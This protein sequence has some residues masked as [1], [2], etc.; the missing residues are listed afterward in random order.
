MSHLAVPRR[1]W[2][3]EHLATFLL[4]RIAFMAHPLT[5]ADDIGSDFFCTLFKA[6]EQ[7]GTEKLFPTNS[8]AIQIKSN[9]DKFSATNKVEYLSALE[10][11]FFVGAVDRAKLQLSIYSGEYIP[12][13]F[14]RTYPTTLTLVPVSALGSSQYC[15][16]ASD[17]QTILRLPLVCEI[18]AHERLED[19]REKGRLLNKL[20]SL[21]HSNISARANSEYIFQLN[22][23]EG[24][25]WMV[26]AGRD[27]VTTFRHNF[28]LR[29]AEV[30]YNFEWILKHQPETFRASEF[31]AYDRFFKQLRD[32]GQTLHP[33]LTDVYARVSRLVNE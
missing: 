25:K 27:S 16:Q 7:D 4:S 2:E 9:A 5:V 13:M 19:L 33:I 11:P 24:R 10:L 23:G 14:S 22:F 28:C 3:N 17:G 8:F 21:M 32:D 20:C 15:E 30:F 29:L 26:V 6:R 12:I 18:S 1:G 31:A